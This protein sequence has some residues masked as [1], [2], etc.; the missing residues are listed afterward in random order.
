MLVV[1]VDASPTVVTEAHPTIPTSS[2]SPE[3]D[4]DQPVI[5]E[6]VIFSI[7]RILV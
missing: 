7:I 1:A 5:I 6:F 3:I 2:T 4:S